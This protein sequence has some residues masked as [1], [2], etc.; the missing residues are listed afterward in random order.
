MILENIYILENTPSPP[1][2]RLPHSCLCSTMPG[3]APK[4]EE[5][6]KTDEDEPV[7]DFDEL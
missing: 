3:L 2:H 6:V 5:E 4:E 1:T 7:I